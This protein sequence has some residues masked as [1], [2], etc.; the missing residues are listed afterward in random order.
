LYSEKRIRG[1]IAKKTSKRSNLFDIDYE[2]EEE[3]E[4][5]LEISLEEAPYIAARCMERIEDSNREL[6]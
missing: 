4:G 2:S 1:K 5:I 6:D 3:S